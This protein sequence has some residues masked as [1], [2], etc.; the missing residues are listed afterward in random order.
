MKKYKDGELAEKLDL[1]WYV[2][3]YDFNRKKMESFNIFN[4]SNF[5]W[6]VSK[7]LKE[8]ESFGKFKGEIDNSLK[9]SFWSKSEYE[10][11]CGDLFVSDINDLE[12]IDVYFQMKDNVDVLSRYILT[13]YNKKKR[14]K[15]EF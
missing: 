2:L 6:G 14:K 1:K 15:I 13:E 3:N 4:S 8:Y 7:A 12:K 11:A 5:L 10:I 9:Y